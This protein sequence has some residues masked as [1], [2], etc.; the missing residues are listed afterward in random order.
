MSSFLP[1]KTFVVCTMQMSPSKGQLLADPGKRDVTVIHSKKDA[2]LLTTADVKLLNDFGCQNKWQGPVVSSFFAAGLL[3]GATLAAVAFSV[4]TLGV[5]AI[6]IGAVAVVATAYSYHAAT[7]NST[8]CNN[9]LTAWQNPHPTVTFNNTAAVT[10]TSFI[11][12]GAGGMLQPFISPSAADSA[13]KRIALANRGEVG[14]SGLISL[15][16]GTALGYAGAS[17][18]LGA[19]AGGSSMLGATGSG[20]FAVGK[21]AGVGLLGAYLVYAPLAHGEKKGMRSWFKSNKGDTTYDRLIANQEST[22]QPEWYEFTYDSP[23]DDYNPTAISKPAGETF[24]RSVELYRINQ[25]D[26]YIERM[27]NVEGTKAEQRAAREA[28][29]KEMSKT[30]SGAEA[31]RNMRRK[32]SGEIE[33]RTKTQTKGNKVTTS[34]RNNAQAARSEAV[35]GTKRKGFSNGMVFNGVALMLPLLVTP[36]DEYTIKAA[37]NFAEED[38]ANGSAV[39]SITH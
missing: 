3:I 32:G 9:L 29:A 19:V 38:I 30:K 4:V 23:D 37:A 13:A 22:E 39:S 27:M 26:V 17:T 11:T 28:I 10:Q 34:H 15:M 20:L 21:E 12:C 14:L 5:G 35:W 25:N 33:P 36:L 24:D 8:K 18:G 16:F 1:E 2:A 31:V 7:S 6:I